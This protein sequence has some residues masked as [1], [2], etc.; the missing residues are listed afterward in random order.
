VLL[1]AWL[2][3]GCGNNAPAVPS[4]ATANAR[5]DKPVALIVS[6]GA[7]ESDGKGNVG[8]NFDNAL[9]FNIGPA[10]AEG[11]FLHMDMRPYKGS[12]TYGEVLISGYPDKR[13]GFFGLGTIVVHADKT[14]GTFS[15][16]DGLA[17]GSWNCGERLK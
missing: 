14:T 9:S 16:D 15:T 3:V 10:T 1:V 6:G 12:G 7:C 4:K 2:A 17:S 5:I 8:A 11:N 13:H